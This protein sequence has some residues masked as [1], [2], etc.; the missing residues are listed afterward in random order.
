MDQ[1]CCGSG[2]LHEGSIWVNTA[3]YQGDLHEESIWIDTAKDQRA[4]HAALW[5][6]MGYM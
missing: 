4:L 5:N 2:S 1:Y 6:N 3:E